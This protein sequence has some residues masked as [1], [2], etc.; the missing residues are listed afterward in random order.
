MTRTRVL[1]EN[2]SPTCPSPDSNSNGFSTA[3]QALGASI[4]AAAMALPGINAAHAEI[5]PEHGSISLK[6]MDYRESQPGLN[7]ITSH[8][9]S[10]MLVAPIAGVWAIEGSLTSDDVSGAS[11]RYHTAITGA[12]KMADVRNAGDVR[13][14]RYFPNGTLSAGAA[15]STEHDYVSRAVSFQGSVSTEDKNRTWTFG[16]GSASDS[17]SPVNGVVVNE[18]KKTVDLLAGVTQVLG[19]DDIAQVNLTHVRGRGYFSDPYKLLDNRP[20]DRNQTTLLARWNHHF[21]ATEGTGRFSYRYYTDTYQIKAHTFGAEYVQPLSQGWV[22]TPSAR[23]YSQSAASF[24]VDPVY[25]ARFGAPFPPNFNFAA[26]DYITEDQRL[27]AF[28]ALTFGV[29]VAK[30]I[31]TDWLL[32]LKL[33]RYEQRANWR[34]FGNGSPGLDPLRATIVQLGITRQW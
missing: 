33:E 5:A 17:I 16:V 19:K 30:R 31:D 11:P 13:V 1:P 23:V 29:K 12:S 3:P 34:L 32:D 2:Y 22:I 28:G 26:N 20:R 8:S 24:Y 6:Y 21:T 14:T 18:S 10:I 7:R 27:S 9:P 25:D 4:L 15:Y